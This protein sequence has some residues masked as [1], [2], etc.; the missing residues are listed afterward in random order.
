MSDL[1]LI[2]EID[3][4]PKVFAR[5]PEILERFQKKEFL[6]LPSPERNEIVNRTLLELIQEVPAPC[7]LL[8]EV[9]NYLAQITI[10]LVLDGTYNLT[11]FER[12]LN[13]H[14]GL[15]Y[16]D[17]RYVRGKIIGKYIPRDDYNSIFPIGQNKVHPGTHT[18]TAHTPPDLDSLTASF[19]GWMDAFGCR[20]GKTLT[21]WNVPRGKPGPII[22]RMFSLFYS[23]ELFYRIAKQKTLISH[24]AMDI[25]QQDR[26]IRARGESDIKELKHNRNQYHIIQVDEKGYYLG[27]W[28]S[29]DVDA[30]SK[31]QRGLNMCMHAYEKFMVLSLTELF[32]ES[33]FQHQLCLEKLEVLFSKKLHDYIH[34]LKFPFSEM[35]E[36]TLHIY[37]TK[38]IGLPQGA[39]TPISEFF[40]L[41]DKKAQTDFAKYR[42]T[43][44]QL[45]NK[46]YYDN[47]L[48]AD[49]EL[50]EVF[51]IIHKAQTL[52]IHSTKN[53]RNYLDRLD[54]AMLIKKAVLEF[55]PTWVSTKAEIHEIRSKIKDYQH[56]TVVFPDKEGHL[57]PV[58]VIHREDID[59]P[60]Q[61]TVSF[62]DFC[63]FDEIKL[64]QDYLELISAIDHH[65]S[66][67]NSKS[68]MV[69]S[70]ADVQSSNIITAQKYFEVNDQYSTRGQST[71]AIDKQLKE[72]HQ[73]EPSQKNLRLTEKLIRK[74]QALLHRGKKFF[75]S[76]ERELQEY[77][78]CLN[79]IIDDTDLLNKCGW[80]DIEVIIDLINRIKSLQVGYE[81]EIFDL[82]GVTKDRRQLKK[83]IH[84]ILK[85][86]DF[87]SFYSVIYEHRENV[88]SELI[89]ATD[90]DDATKIFEDRKIQNHSCSISQFKLFPRNWDDLKTNR[91]NILLNWL[92]LRRRIREKSSEVDF[93]LHMMSTVPGAKEAFANELDVSLGTDEI[94]LTGVTE[95]DESMSRIRQFLR[96]LNRSPKHQ[97][98]NLIFHIEGPNND[99][100]NM[101][102][103]AVQ[104]VYPEKEIPLIENEALEV[105]II[106][107]RFNQGAL[108]SRKA[109]ITPFLPK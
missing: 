93:F 109:D 47:D 84:N 29:T 85:C 43:L 78:L 72:L 51:S 27:D 59:K 86:K 52:L 91:N 46:D 87:Y 21:V 41:M 7:F 89:L 25:V 60:I 90:D 107:F 23:D 83:I 81:I 36:H 63:N 18:V 98:I 9:T 101:L 3:I 67:V 2:G 31:V 69:L 56:I 94:W 19:L 71:E 32:S 96:A 75:V 95:A 65:K 82:D 100:S 66:S 11:A 16:E 57:I 79:A 76:P 61:G 22:A 30:V 68:A 73:A 105:G 13:Q 88:V 1:P 102:R 35:Q 64:H 80:W 6:E 48:T 42:E 103:K 70:V 45:G 108:N 24:V 5:Q 77:L 49:F 106:I 14:S 58:G 54:V 50:E 10:H 44:L 99:S 38:V 92:Q 15:N 55:Q 4:Q 8:P 26:L 12:W 20:V 39:N 37:L 33:H 28:R 53:L 97:E 62:R 34:I 17:N 74:K 104:S 40:T